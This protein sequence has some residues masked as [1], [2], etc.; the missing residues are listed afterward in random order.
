MGAAVAGRS[1]PCLLRR[2]QSDS[3]DSKI[4]SRFSSAAL[5][6]G[7]MITS[8]DSALASDGSVAS[9]GPG[10]SSWPDSAAAEAPAGAPSTGMCPF[11]GAGAV[12][13]P[14]SAGELATAGPAISNRRRPGGATVVSLLMTSSGSQTKAVSPPMEA[15]RSRTRMPCRA[16]SRATTNRPI[17]RDTA[18]STT[19]GLSSRQFACAI[20]SAPIPTP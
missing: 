14:E 9:P 10:A 11:S 2:N 15:G 20:S 8:G 12:T 7:G 18:T 6:A 4:G 1:T 16:A 3:T 13:T 19:G 17:R 5:G